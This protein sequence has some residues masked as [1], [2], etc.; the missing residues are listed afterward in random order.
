[1]NAPKAPNFTTAAMKPV[2]MCGLPSYTSGL[3]KWKG[4]APTLNR[5]ALKIIN[6]P[7]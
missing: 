7:T 6:K 3:Q 2:T 1:M 5:K 4:T